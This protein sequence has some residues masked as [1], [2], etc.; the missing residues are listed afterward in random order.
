[1]SGKFGTKDYVNRA[2]E[3]RAERQKKGGVSGGKNAKR[4]PK[5]GR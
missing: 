1:M 3:I 2:D 5:K 4:R